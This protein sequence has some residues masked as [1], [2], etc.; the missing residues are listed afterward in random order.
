LLFLLEFDKSKI[1]G[2]HHWIGQAIWRASAVML[3]LGFIFIGARGYAQDVA[4]IEGEMVVTAKWAAQNLP[5]DAIIAAHDIGALGYYDN[6]EL[7][8][9][10]GLVSP[11]VIPF[12]RDEPRLEKYL[13]Q[14]GANYLIAFPDFYPRMTANAEVA[15]ETHN[16][17]TLTLGQKNMAV[18]RWK[19]HK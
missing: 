4:V 19:S 15:F 7:I 16:P 18:Y 3:T 11:E 2:R 10:A 5:A 17:V 1:F 12:I 8:D 14:R 6:H 13:N 9:L